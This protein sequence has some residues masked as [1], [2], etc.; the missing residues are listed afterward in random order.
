MCGIIF[1]DNMSIACMV[2]QS[3]TE[4]QWSCCNSMPLPLEHHS[5]LCTL[6]SSPKHTSKFPHSNV[7]SASNY[8]MLIPVRIQSQTRCNQ[9]YN[10]NPMLLKHQTPQRCSFQF[11]GSFLLESAHILYPVIHS[12]CISCIW[13][14]CADGTCCPT[15]SAVLV[16][17]T[18][19]L[20][21]RVTRI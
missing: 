13:S 17:T 5:V 11:Y 14:A 7:R 9:T 3:H 8:S 20:C 18:I 15:H 4:K 21:S 10:R 6:K 1:W 19:I 2:V 12:S 16:V